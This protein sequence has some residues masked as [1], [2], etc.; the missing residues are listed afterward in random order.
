MRGSWQL[1]EWKQAD[2]RTLEVTARMQNP[3]PRAIVSAWEASGRFADVTAE[4]GKQPGSV[5]VKAHVLR[6]SAK[7]GSKPAGKEAKR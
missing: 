6:K 7:S 5:V 1:L 2:S 4:L 3:D